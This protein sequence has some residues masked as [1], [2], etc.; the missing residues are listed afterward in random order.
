MSRGSG[1]R[2]HGYTSADGAYAHCAR[3]ECGSEE[4]GGTYAHR[5]EAPCRCGVPHVG[6]GASEGASA[7]KPVSPSTVDHVAAWANLATRS[8]VGERY[9]AGRGLNPIDLQGVVKYSSA[10]SPTLPLRDLV[11]G[12]AVGS[13]YRRIDGAS[14]GPKVLSTRGSRCSGAALHGRLAELA[15]DGVDVAIV[16][17]G[18][19]DTLAAFLAWPGCAVFGS[20]GA[21]QLE[22]MTLAI[23]PHVRAIRGWLLLVSDADEIG[24]RQGVRAAQAALSCG[25]VLDRDLHLVDLGEHHDLA[26]AWA[27]GWRWAWS[28]VA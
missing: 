7:G 12:E 4:S 5:L 28:N 6:G 2:C 8:P 27:H 13:Q 24:I 11:T 9:L 15:G 17:E 14:E 25:L 26:D 22:R 3:I 10:G 18:L 23:A 20:P 21:A 19:A 1:K 16:C